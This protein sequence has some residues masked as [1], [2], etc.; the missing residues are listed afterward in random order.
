MTIIGEVSDLKQQRTQLNDE[1]ESRQ[2]KLSSLTDDYNELY[3]E[4][5]TLRAERDAVQQI[6]EHVEQQHQILTS[7]ANDSE[8]SKY[9]RN[10]LYIRS[11]IH[12]V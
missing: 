8:R 7:Q 4:V 12:M 11:T 3:T 6:K 5:T 2:Q 9:Y 1:L 10:V